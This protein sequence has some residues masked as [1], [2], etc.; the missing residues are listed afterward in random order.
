V[1][2]TDAGTAINMAKNRVRP[3]VRGQDRLSSWH[4]T[5]ET[6]GTIVQMIPFTRIAWHAG[7]DTAKIVPG[8]GYANYCTVGIEL[9]GRTPG[10]FPEAQVLGYARLLRAIV[11]WAGIEREHAMITHSSIDPTR[12]HD[13]GPEWEV[14]HAQRV[15]ELAFA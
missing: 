13:P 9:V 5:V 11:Q 4:A 3:F 6:D 10:P 7:S 15:L 14:R 12:R 8:L 2:D 1:S